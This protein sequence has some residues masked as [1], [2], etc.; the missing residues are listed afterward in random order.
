MEEIQQTVIE[1]AKKLYSE[2]VEKGLSEEI[3]FK[4]VGMQYILFAI[5]ESKLL[6]LLF[7]NEQENAP[8]FL[9]VLPLI[10]DSYEKILFSIQ[11]GSSMD[12]YFSK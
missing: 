8:D 11:N 2:Y 4:G 12:K 10:D 9:S 6:Q 5:K 3:P 1:A 7:M